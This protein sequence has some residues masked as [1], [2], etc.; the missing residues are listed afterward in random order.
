VSL[1]VIR[2]NKRYAVRRA[3]SL[4]H[5]GDNCAE[6]L[7]IEISQEGCR[8]SSLDAREFAMGQPATVEICGFGKLT[9]T[10]RWAHDAVMGLR[11]DAPLHNDVLGQ[12]ITMCRDGD[13]ATGAIRSYGT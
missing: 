7:L 9:A 1:F 10:V 6:G 5:P 8:I 4:D 11:F 12:L 13:E 3:V 2:S